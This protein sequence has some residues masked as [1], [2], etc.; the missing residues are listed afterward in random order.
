MLTKPLNEHLLWK[1]AIQRANYPAPVEKPPIYV[2]TKRNYHYL[3]NH[4]MAKKTIE[5]SRQY[6]EGE[7]LRRKA[8]RERQTEE[9]YMML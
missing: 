5:M 6:W 3:T 9:Q 7:K 2:N 4:Y 1:G 8:Y